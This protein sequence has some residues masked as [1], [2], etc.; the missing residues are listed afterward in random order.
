MTLP[1]RVEWAELL[2]NEV[3]LYLECAGN[4]LTARVSPKAF[5]EPGAEIRIA[6]DTEKIHHFDPE[7]E[8]NLQ[9]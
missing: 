2:G 9:A 6:F 1:A 5:S 3:L 8:E 7:T 4:R